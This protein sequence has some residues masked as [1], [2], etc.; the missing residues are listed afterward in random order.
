MTGDAGAL[1][2][3]LRGK[4]SRN[5]ERLRRF[6]YTRSTR[7][8]RALPLLFMLVSAVLCLG[9]TGSDD[10][11]A[12]AIK[13][14]LRLQESVHDSNSLQ[15]SRAVVT[16]K[17]ICIEYRNRNA[18]GGMSTGFA[19][20]KTDK[21]LVWV[22]NSWL[23]DQVCLVGKYGQRRE[24][25][26]VTDAVN[27]AIEGKQAFVFK[28]PPTPSA[29]H[30][31][32]P[33]TP[34]V[35]VAVPAARVET[36]MLSGTITVPPVAPKTGV[37][38]RTAHA[39]Q[40][41]SSSAPAAQASVATP[42]P[43]PPA[44]VPEAQSTAAVVPVGTPGPTAQAPIGIAPAVVPVPGAQPKLALPAVPVPPPSTALYAVAPAPVASVELGTIRGVTI[45]DNSG[46]MERK[47]PPPAP[48][49]LAD[50]A[51]R[52]RQSKPR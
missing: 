28:M 11:T 30:R 13:G 8:R 21:D 25:K 43:A 15:V 38:R 17:G 51:R 52:L 5:S 23:W 19:V 20:Y 10:D 12:H 34:A 16:N 41:A 45:V 9:R 35:E 37:S 1:V 24:G 27:A 36:L 33:T 31:E 6:Y 26:D 50:V 22:D 3:W 48:E 42:V 2:T 47:G 40:L 46:A 32:D 7:K 44:T 49:S 18:F 39:A 29:P 14:I 4:A